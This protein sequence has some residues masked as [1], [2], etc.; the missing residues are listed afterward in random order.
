MAYV[1][2]PIARTA[3]RV[4]RGSSAGGYLAG[5]TWV[6]LDVGRRVRVQDDVA[7]L[8][9]LLEDQLFSSNQRLARAQRGVP[10]D[11]RPVEEQLGTRQFDGVK[12]TGRR[13]TT[14][15]PL[16]RVGNDRPIQIVD[17]QWESPELGI[18]VYSRYSDPRTAVVEYQLTNIGRA[19]PRADLFVVPPDYTII[20]AGQPGIRGNAP[21]AQRQGGAR[22]PQ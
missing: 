19:E 7:G 9:L 20:G 17:E 22:T 11:V 14:I 18:V 16:G 10:G 15:I 6:P 1:L 4:P 3:R 8:A 2:D 5:V 21:G 12:A 13:T